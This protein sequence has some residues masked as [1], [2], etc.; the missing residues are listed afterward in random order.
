[1]RTRL[2]N[3]FD[4]ELLCN[5]PISL[6]DKDKWGVPIV[7]LCQRVDIVSVTVTQT[8]TSQTDVENHLL[9]G[10]VRS[11]NPPTAIGFLLKHC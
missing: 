6:G 8:A 11:N 7:A 9:R 4:S 2:Y 1:M 3:H 10:V 5:A